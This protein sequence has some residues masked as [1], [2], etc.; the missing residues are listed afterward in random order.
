MVFFKGTK[1]CNISISRQ[2]MYQDGKHFNK[3]GRE[4][5]YTSKKEYSDDALDFANK[6]IHNPNAQIYEEI[7]NGKGNQNGQT[8]IVIT[9]DNKTVIIN[10]N[11]GQV[12]DFYEGTDYRGLIDLHKIR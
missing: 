4:M 1:G 3:R 8:Q 7:W 9:Y 2:R 11:S 12:I 5:G 10:K 6:N